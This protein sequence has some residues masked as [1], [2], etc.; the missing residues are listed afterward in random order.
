MEWRSVPADSATSSC[1]AAW[2]V[3][4]S[5]S[6]EAT[7]LRPTA[8]RTSAGAAPVHMPGRGGTSR[9]E[10]LGRISARSRVCRSPRSQLCL[11][12]ISADSREISG[13]LGQ[14]RAL[15]PPRGL[16][17]RVR[18]RGGEAR[19]QRAHHRRSRTRLRLR[20]IDRYCCERTRPRSSCSP[21]PPP[22]CLGRDSLRQQRRVVTCSQ[23]AAVKR[24]GSLVLRREVGCG[25]ASGPDL[26]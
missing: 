18:R 4:P 1:G 12:R 7:K 24:R 20:L 25:V 6:S 15:P 22:P 8:A 13:N 11:G 19:Q 21:P 16:L 5:G 2:S 23:L 14:S 3:E 26:G 9:A 10:H 17:K